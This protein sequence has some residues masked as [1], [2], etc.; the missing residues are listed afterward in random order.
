MCT[1]F[2]LNT[3][4]DLPKEIFKNNLLKEGGLFVLEHTPRNN[5]KEFDFFAREKNYGTTV[6]SFFQL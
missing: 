5:Y 2:G 3:I 1:K 4:D 6:F